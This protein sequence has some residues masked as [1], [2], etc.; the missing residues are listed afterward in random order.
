MDRVK[1]GLHWLLLLFPV[2]AWGQERSPSAVP[3]D[4]LDWWR[5]ARFGLFVHWGLYAIPAGKWG[6][7]TD[8]A[9]WILTT[10]EIPVLEY[11]RF[12]KEFDPSAFDADRWV[13]LAKDAGMRYVVITTKHH[14][15]FCLFDSELTDYDV[16]ST[17]FRRDVMKELAEACARQGLRICW[18][19]S[20]MD[21]HHPDYLP[22]RAWEDRSAQ[23]AD[24]ARYQEYLF[25]QVRELLTN[26]GPIGVM[27][28]DGEWE[29]TW[30]HEDGVQL[31]EHVRALQPGVIVNNRV[32]KGR[33]GMAGMTLGSE[34]RG[35]FGTPEQEIPATGLPGVDWETCMTMNRN[36]GYNA[37][38]KDFKST[39]DLVRKLIDVASKGGNFL[40]NVGPTSRGEFPPECV[41]RLRAIGEWMKVHGDAIYG[42]QASPFEGL[43]FGRCTKKRAGENSTLFLHVFEWPADGRLVV[44]GLGSEVLSARSLTS[45]GG[46]LGFER[47]G[48][49]VVVRVPPAAPNPIATVVALEVRGEPI[50]YETPRILAD[51]HMLVKELPLELAVNSKELEIR[52]TLDGSDPTAGSSLYGGP[53][54]IS[55]TTTVRAR[56]FHEGRAV[57]GAA[58]RRFVRVEP[59][60]AVG[61]LGQ[62][63]GL[64][65]ETFEGDWDELPDMLELDPLG[66]E[67][68]AQVGLPRAR[69]GEEHFALR[70][71]GYLE[72]PEDDVYRFAL[73]SDDGSELWIDG[74]LVVDNDGLHSLETKRGVAA[75]AKGA[76]QIDVRYFNKTGGAELTLAWGRPGE[77]LVSVPSAKLS[78]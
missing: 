27:W 41:E 40:L 9:E 19:H 49:D 15:G 60:P 37:A 28:F 55:A 26:Y 3:E 57:S 48:P 10:A 20:I 74:D 56:S 14:D 72:I 65:V 33:A 18:Y 69:R 46:E 70:I 4:R 52:Y 67:T 47:A 44:P 54:R 29:S 34:F 1:R 11:Q 5:E 45:G 51:A 66:S 17:P 21:W 23:G 71:H 64:C 50:V 63:A 77:T 2:C 39:A 6:G 30:Q 36:W 61:A 58:E 24:F 59:L 35:D 8:H 16:M 78:R 75:L 53:F 62:A 42:T 12:T 38:D 25:G 68:V 32:D 76:H 13:S 31:Y 43:A 73:S 22:R 7:S